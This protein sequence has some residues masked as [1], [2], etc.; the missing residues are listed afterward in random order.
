MAQRVTRQPD[1]DAADMQP[2][3]CYNAIHAVRSFVE[4]QCSL[5]SM[6]MD[7]KVKQGH[8]NETVY[9]Y[10]IDERDEHNRSTNT[11]F[12]IG[13]DLLYERCWVV[14]NPNWALRFP[15]DTH[16]PKNGDEL[17]LVTQ[18]YITEE[19]AKLEKR[20]ANEHTYLRHHTAE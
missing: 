18:R 8:D 15:S 13:I 10:S 5:L 19:I 3:E 16:V 7:W 11:G 20:Y 14:G 17:P 9:V 1:K 2:A 6:T 12:Y 4:T